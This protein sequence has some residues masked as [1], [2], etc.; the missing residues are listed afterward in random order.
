MSMDNTY[1]AL[2]TRSHLRHILSGAGI[3]LAAVALTNLVPM[4]N[5]LSIPLTILMLGTALFLII[6]SSVGRNVE[7]CLTGA[8]LVVRRHG[9]TRLRLTKPIVDIHQ[10]HAGDA[11]TTTGCALILRDSAG[12]KLRIGLLGVGT[13]RAANTT[14]LQYDV[15]LDDPVAG[16]SV[17]SWVFGPDRLAE[18][19][20][21]FPDAPDSEPTI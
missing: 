12:S 16:K 9:K 5:A 15:L 1:A 3:I 8:D 6:S 17:L 14:L 7:L 2:W 19:C 13:L 18:I 10:H 11:D 20:D 21:F 4:P